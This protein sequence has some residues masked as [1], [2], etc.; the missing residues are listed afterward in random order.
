MKEEETP[1]WMNHPTPE[2]GT[3][4]YAEYQAKQAQRFRNPAFP[5]TKANKE[6]ADM[7][8][9]YALAW[10]PEPDKKN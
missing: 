3:K 8:E 9:H 7:Y 1:Y 5:Q 2:V 4:E 6:W 10:L